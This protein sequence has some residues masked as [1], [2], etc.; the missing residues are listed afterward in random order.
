[1]A[2]LEINQQTAPLP[3]PIRGLAPKPVW[4]STCPDTIAAY[5]IPNRMH[6]S[7]AWEMAAHRITI[8]GD[9]SPACANVV[10]RHGM[11]KEACHSHQN[12]SPQLGLDRAGTSAEGL[13]VS[14]GDAGSGI[15]P[16]HL[17]SPAY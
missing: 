14:K 10:L 2:Q 5:N 16:E 15:T 11:H 4:M 8:H 12:Y 17:G 1:M 3:R 6:Q 13:R 7:G 9:G